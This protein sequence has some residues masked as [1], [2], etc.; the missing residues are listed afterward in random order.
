[1]RFIAGGLNGH[2]LL[3][4]AE[5]A[6]TEA[7]TDHVQAAIAYAN[8]KPKLI[9]FCKEHRTYLEFWCLYDKSVPVNPLILEDFLKSDP[10]KYRCKLINGF[11]HSK[12]IW[13]HSYGVYIGSA[14]LTDRS[15]YN[16]IEAG[17]FVP[18]NEFESGNL[19]NELIDFFNELDRRSTGLTKGHLDHQ[20]ALQ[21]ARHPIQKLEEDIA[22]HHQTNE[23]VPPNPPLNSANY[24]KRQTEKKE[25]FL[26]EWGDTMSLLKAIG[27][28]IQSGAR[29]AWLDPNI[30]LS[31]QT[32][33]FLHA[34][35]EGYVEKGRKSHHFELHEDNQKDP[36]RAVTEALNWWKQQPIR[37]VDELVNTAAETLYEILKRENLASLTSAQNYDLCRY[38]FSIAEHA[39]HMDHISYGLIEPLPKMSMPER[40]QYFANW[41][42]ERR[43]PNKSGF[44]QTLDYLLYSGNVGD[45]PVRIWEV[46]RQDGPYKI[47]HI[48]VNNLGEIVGR[49]F[50]NDFSPRNGRTN[51]ALYA[52]GNKVTLHADSR[53]KPTADE[54]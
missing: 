7:K 16:N 29:P 1:M 24:K 39:Q 42:M 36:E 4:L 40:I 9:D 43:S 23:L 30:P 5:R 12:V 47:P 32:D 19:G 51:K 44:L 11:F 6:H 49:A 14:N 37:P 10:I 33:R 48:G 41:I 17:L 15:W 13:W 35:Y 3:E 46:S 20:L 26:K 53:K 28:K 50:P 34:Y 18:E 2:Q 31:A 52:L 45:A 21:K 25:A 8:N 54:N 22:R 38:I 27:L